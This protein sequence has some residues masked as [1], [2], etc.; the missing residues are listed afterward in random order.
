MTVELST[1]KQIFYC[2]DY[3]CMGTLTPSRSNHDILVCSMCALKVR[4]TLAEKWEEI[5]DIS[6][7]PNGM[8]EDLLQK[9]IN[10][11]MRYNHD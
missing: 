4:R 2:P 9:I 7:I 6:P 1:K 11:D 10:F 8:L 3:S 5:H